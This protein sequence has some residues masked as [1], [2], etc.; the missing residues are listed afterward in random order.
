MCSK[1][2]LLDS[3]TIWSQKL[4]PKEIAIGGGEP[5]LHPN[6]EELLLEIRR[7]WSKAKIMVISNGLLLPQVSDTTLKILAKN[8][9][10]VRISQHIPDK[11]HHELLQ[12]QQSRLTALGIRCCFFPSEQHW[13]VSYK[14]DEHGIPLPLLSN[15]HRAYAHCCSRPCVFIRKR[16]L[17]RCNILAEIYHGVQNGYL[18]PAWNMAL[19]HR[20]MTSNDVNKDILEYLHGSV[21]KEC[22]LCRDDFTHVEPCQIPKEQ[23][24]EIKSLIKEYRKAG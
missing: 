23:L 19:K 9:I 11:K 2:E 22:T 8:D 14:L 3:F 15:P 21:M 24:Y 4:L 17:W 13:R 18:P 12:D 6:Y 1:E 20:Y 10:S 5:F 7:L 16:T